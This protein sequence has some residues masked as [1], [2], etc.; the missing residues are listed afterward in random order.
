MEKS[1]F[2]KSWN[3]K[4][5]VLL[6]IFIF[7]LS[8]TILTGLIFFRLGQQNSTSPDA[9]SGQVRDAGTSSGTMAVGDEVTFRIYAESVEDLYGYQFQFHYNTDALEYKSLSSTIDDIPTIFQ[10]PVDDYLLV[11]ATKVGKVEGFSGQ[12]V[13]VCEITMVAKEEGEI[14]PVVLEEVSVVDSQLEY[15]EGVSDWTYEVGV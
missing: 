1:R 15:Y 14:P 11:G 4:S 3:K 6:L 13:A 8:S 9:L 7:T 12:D 10:N 2:R 5:V